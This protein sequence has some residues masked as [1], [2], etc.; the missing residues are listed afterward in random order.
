MGLSGYM[1]PEYAMEGI[2]SVKSDV[3]S[4]GVLI[5]D[6]KQAWRLWNDGKAQELIDRNLISNCLVRK[7]S[8]WINI[9]LLC[10]QENPDDR[11]SMSKATLILGGQSTEITKPSEPPFSVGR[12]PLSNQCSSTRDGTKPASVSLTL[13]QE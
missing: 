12:Y 4:F 7:V 2:F 8:I 1:A 6:S 10:V 13:P 5:Y 3:Y 9:A 11:P